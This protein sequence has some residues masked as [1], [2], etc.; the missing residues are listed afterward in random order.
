MTKPLVMFADDDHGLLRLY[1][2]AFRDE[3]VV[4][5]TSTL[6]ETERVFSESR[7]RLRALVIDASMEGDEPDT[8][9]FIRRVRKTGFTGLIIGV[10]SEEG[11]LEALREAG[12]DYCYKKTPG[13]EFINSLWAIF[14]DLKPRG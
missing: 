11:S 5:T 14:K 13:R 1:R 8:P 7:T 4:T 6:R 3:L 12:C 9:P 2:H 10:S